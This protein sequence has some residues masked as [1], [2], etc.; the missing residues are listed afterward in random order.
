MKR[1]IAKCV[2]SFIDLIY[3]PLCIHC[4]DCLGERESLLCSTCL[5]CMELIDLSDRCPYCFSE[6]Y[7]PEMGPCCQK[8]LHANSYEPVGRIAAAFD[9]EGPA[10]SIV[11]QMKYGN[12]PYLAKGASAYLTAQF[13]RLQWPFPDYIVPM[14]MPSFR[15]LERGYNQSALLA[16]SMAALLGCRFIDPLRRKNGDFAQAGLNHEQRL[17]LLP[18]KFSIKKGTK[19]HD[20]TVLLID[21]VMTTGSSLQCAAKALAESCPKEIYAMVLCC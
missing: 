3:T 4:E 11:K 9:Y 14:P 15:K 6:G 7:A 16:E 18:E 12:Q 1:L 10:A 2:K 8:C 20:A 17:Q 13:L 19:L 21:D 5:N